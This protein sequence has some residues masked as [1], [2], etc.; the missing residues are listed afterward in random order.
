[1]LDY[2]LVKS[3]VFP[4]VVQSYTERD[5]MLYALGLGFGSDP[6]AQA[7]LPFVYEKDLVAVPT[8]AAVLG[9]SGF[10]WQN[11]AFGADWVKIVHGEQDIEWC[12]PMP[13]SGTVVGRNRVLGLTDKG[14]GKG[15]LAQVV[16]ELSDATTGELIAKVRQVT[17][18]RGNGGYSTES[19]LSDP[20]PPALPQITDD[21]GEPDL[22]LDLPTL[23]QAA[24]IYRLSGDMNPLHAD[25]SI[26]AEA[27]YDLPIL[28]GLCTY[29]MAAR[30]LLQTYLKHDPAQLHR[31]AARFTSPVFPGET[32]TF[33]F[34][35]KSG[36]R[37]ALRARILARDV[38][39]LNN[40]FAE[41]GSP[42]S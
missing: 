29:G 23:P 13:K 2:T 30:A 34:W 11:P 21:I 12:R 38:T 18:L 39:V 22:E 3:W 4:D 28:H 19:G 27:G 40:G 15:V 26:A 35:R 7:E 24:L 33:Q 42:R 9:S 25:P 32:I 20:A 8:Q 17:F 5:T 36:T 10:I 31:L 37:V 16:R 41:I 6:L 14:P 1:M